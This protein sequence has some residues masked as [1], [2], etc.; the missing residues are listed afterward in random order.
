M[1]TKNNLGQLVNEGYRKVSIAIMPRIPGMGKLP[2]R[3]ARRSYAYTALSDCGQSVFAVFGWR[4][5]LD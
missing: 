5:D 3:S 4:F 1:R 2:L